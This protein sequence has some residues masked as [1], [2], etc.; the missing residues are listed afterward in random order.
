MAAHNL[1]PPLLLFLLASACASTDVQHEP[2][3]VAEAANKAPAAGFAAPPV[4]D[5]FAELETSLEAYEQ[6][7]ARNEARLRAM[8]VLVATRDDN[9]MAEAEA[10]SRF[11]PPPPMT[12]PPRKSSDLGD[13]DQGAAGG[14]RPSEAARPDARA[15]DARDKESEKAKKRASR[16]TPTGGAAKPGTTSASTPAPSSAPRTDAAADSS[17]RTEARVEEGR[18]R[19]AELCDLADST[20]DLEGKICD[21]AARHPG[22]ARF[23]EVCRRADEDCRIAAEACTLCSP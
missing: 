2:R 19:C 1:K 10:P 8:G 4:D 21:L 12:T 5:E 3:P 9:A 15:K 14:T 13:H 22:E 16:P 18:G 7:L 17:T 6:Q 23:A 20:C 11:A